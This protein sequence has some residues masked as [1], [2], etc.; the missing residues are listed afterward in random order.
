MVGIMILL[1]LLI[2]ICYHHCVR[3]DKKKKLSAV[4]IPC[5]IAKYSWICSDSFTYL[6]TY[7]M[8]QGPSWEAS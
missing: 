4:L 1:S 8:E 6:L 5:S 3:S 2:D 7:S